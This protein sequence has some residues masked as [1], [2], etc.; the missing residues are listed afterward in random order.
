[1][2]LAFSWTGT[3]IVSYIINKVCKKNEGAILAGVLSGSALGAV[4]F[5]QIV[6][7]FI[8]DNSNPFGYRNVYFIMAGIFV[9]MFFLLLFFFKEPRKDEDLY[10][11]KG[12][13]ARGKNWIGIEYGQA[14]KKPYFYCVCV[15]LSGVVLS[16]MSD[17]YCAHMSDRGI[18]VD[19]V[20]LVT[21]ISAIVILIFKLVIGIIYDHAGLRVTIIITS[22]SAI[23]AA[24]CLLFVGN[25]SIGILFAVLFIVFRPM[26]MPMELFIVPFYAKDLFGEKSFQKA[27]GVFS[28]ITQV[29]IAVASPIC[30]AFYDLFGS[31]DIA[32]LLCVGFML[33]TFIALQ[34]IINAAHRMRKQIENEASLTQ[35][36]PI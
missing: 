8:G 15:F 6:T 5:T 14:L 13:K 32:L 36:N 25:T 35:E 21:S 4:I 17:L 23:L 3:P 28:S 9:V 22:L 2:G 34:F 27:V 33:L 10:V 29:G 30:N 18:N 19:T 1:M 26:A 24:L 31:Y 16:G 7:P 20:A 12:K 11:K